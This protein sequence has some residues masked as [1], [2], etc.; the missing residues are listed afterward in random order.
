LFNDDD[1]DFCDSN[2][3]EEV[4]EE[5]EKLKPPVDTDESSDSKEKSLILSPS[6]PMTSLIVKKPPLKLIIKR[7]QHPTISTEIKYKLHPVN[8]SLPIIT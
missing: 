4:E 3:D 5:E 2:D 6:I 8:T 1:N 7:L